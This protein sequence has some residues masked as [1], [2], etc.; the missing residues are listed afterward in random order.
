M[1]SIFEKKIEGNEPRFFLSSLKKYFRS[2]S[3]SDRYEGMVGNF[4]KWSRF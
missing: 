2:E 1:I 3:K 4:T